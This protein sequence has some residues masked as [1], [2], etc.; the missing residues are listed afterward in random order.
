MDVPYEPVHQVFAARAA[1]T[2]DAISVEF[3]DCRLS[4]AELEREANRLAHHLISLGVGP[5]ILVAVLLDRS[6]Q[7]YIA[8]VAALKAGGAVVP[9]DPAYPSQRLQRMLDDS[10]P[11]ILVTRSDLSDL[12]TAAAATHVVLVDV[13]AATIAAGP[14]IAPAQAHTPRSLAYVLYT[15][16][17]TGT[18]K[19]VMLEHAGLANI[20]RWVARALRYTTA[21]RVALLIPLSFDAAAFELWP[22]LMSGACCVAIEEHVRNDVAALAETVRAAG[23][24]VVSMVTALA[25]L[26]LA[27]PGLDALPLRCLFQGGETVHAWPPS[28]L[29]FDVVNVYGPAESSV[30]VTMAVLG[31]S[32][33]DTGRVPIGWP[34]DGVD[35]HLLDSAGRPVPD[36]A[37]GEICV[38]GVAV[39]RGYRGQPALTATRFPPDPFGVEPGGRLYLT[40]DL[41][42]RR[43]DGAIEFLGRRDQQVKIRGHRVELAEVESVLGQH[44]GVTSAVARVHGA[45]ASSAYLVGYVVPEKRRPRVASLEH[46]WVR[47][48][49]RVAG[50]AEHG[51][52]D[53]VGWNSSYTGKP[54]PRR[55]MRDWLDETVA[56]IQSFHPRDVVEIGCGTGMIVKTIGPDVRSYVGLDLSAEALEHLARRL[57]SR[58]LGD[59]V[60]LLEREATDLADLPRR[61]FDTAVINSVVQYFPS[62]E[63]LTAALEGVVDLVAD[64]G[65]VLVGDVRSLPLQTA[66]QT[67]LVLYQATDDLSV[68]EFVSQVH[69]G[70]AHDPELTVHP[71]L[72]GDLRQR[73][74]RVGAVEVRP[75][76][77]RYANELTTFRY[78]VVLHVGAADRAPVDVTWRDWT[79]DGMCPERLR[80]LL[81]SGTEPVIGVTG[82]PNARTVPYVAAWT[83]ATSAGPAATVAQLRAAAAGAEAGLSATALAELTAGTDYELFL[84]WLGG[85]ADGALDAVWIKRGHTG[86]RQPEIAFPTGGGIPS[87]L[88]SDPL[89][90]TRNAALAADLR[91]YVSE[92]L[93]APMVPDFIVALDEFPLTPV[94][95]VD[96]ARLPAPSKRSA[97]TRP[98]VSPRTSAE[99]AVVAIAGEV[100]GVA[101]DT[102]STDDDLTDIGAN[103]LTLTQ[104]AVRIGAYLDVHVSVRDLLTARTV[105]A[106]AAVVEDAVLAEG[107]TADG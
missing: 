64:G 83:R 77:G 36:G 76:R 41:G 82:V 100:F 21:D 35:I 56:Q 20:S 3:P 74:A 39:G 40:G 96:R 26:F 54:L 24:T 9:L 2:P 29:P 91:R 92:R 104:I 62:V 69:L 99:K 7:H 49:R 85:R 63:Y 38:G 31:D 43:S 73:L 13:E 94:G 95:K 11:P 28:G 34:I 71:A 101:A 61:K 12:V 59:R 8:L 105:A 16:G 88:A 98:V 33:S 70:T 14:D 103:S 48:W 84:S 89:A 23:L 1:Q 65:K 106:I 102:L 60:K 75:K 93:P 72:F 58:G 68:E 6:P 90:R 19:G 86:G 66:F 18:P 57:R 4:Y 17:S 44:E 47:D 45:T 30:I 5:E 46:E 80:E 42:R 107:S 97:R 32:P 53:L 79:A 37:T 78:D 52:G 10:S 50:A 51:N 27:L 81:A 55:E 25:D 67:S 15:S 87:A 22:A